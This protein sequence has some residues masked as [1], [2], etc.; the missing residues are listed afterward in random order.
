[1]EEEIE[2]GFTDE[3]LI[4]ELF[5]M[6][7]RSFREYKY[8]AIE[9]FFKFGG[10]FLVNLGNTLLVADLSNSIKLIH[11]FRK[12]CAEHEMLWR[13]HQAKE[14]ANHPNCL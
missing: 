11:L 3:Y 8:N 2:Q 14:K 4:K 5:G 12:E 6:N 1:M 10:N 7:E 13:I 9:G